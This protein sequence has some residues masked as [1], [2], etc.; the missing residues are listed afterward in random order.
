MWRTHS[1]T[2]FWITCSVEKVKRLYE[3]GYEDAKANAHTTG[4]AVVAVY[5]D[6]QLSVAARLLDKPD[7]QISSALKSGEI[8]GKTGELLQLRADASLPCKRILLVGCGKRGALDRQGFR[9]AMQA[10]SQWLSKKPFKD[11]TNYLTLEAVKGANVER[12]A[13]IAAQVWLHRTYRFTQMKSKPG[14]TAPELKKMTLAAK[15]AAAARALR[16]G[17]AYGEAL[18]NGGDNRDAAGNRGL[19]RN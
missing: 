4:L 18:G 12:R 15:D 5:E 7:G 2:D 11:A 13:A 14:D 3:L 1:I 19:E 17:A 16:K 8:S 6:K 10:V 9:T